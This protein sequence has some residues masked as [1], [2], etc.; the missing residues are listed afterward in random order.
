M[1]KY[2]SDSERKPAAPTWEKQRD[3]ELIINYYV[4][5]TLKDHAQNWCCC[6]IL[7]LFIHELFNISYGVQASVKLSTSVLV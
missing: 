6:Y 1:V 7:F 5:I 2:H 3:R 4:A